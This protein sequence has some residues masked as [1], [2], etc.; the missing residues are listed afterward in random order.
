MCVK[1]IADNMFNFKIQ[2]ENSPVCIINVQVN[3]DLFDAR[4]AHIALLPQI[5]RRDK[6]PK[7]DFVFIK[8]HFGM[9]V[10]H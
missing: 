2:L 8:Y 3:L 10:D 7:N 9:S 5:G 6:L 1:I 4:G